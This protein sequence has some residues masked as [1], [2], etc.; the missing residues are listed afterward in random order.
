M[1]FKCGIIGLP[2]VGKTTLFSA[3]TGA[4]AEAVNT[5]KREPNTILVKVPDTRLDRIAELIPPQKVTHAVVEFIDIAGVSQGSS[6]LSTQFL[7][8]MREMDALIHVIR[9]FEDPNVFHI[10]NTLDAVRDAEHLNMELALNDLELCTKRLSTLEKTIRTGKKEGEALKVILEKCITALE[11]GKNLRSLGLTKDETFLLRDLRLLTLK[12]VLYVAN[13]SEADLNQSNPMVQKLEA[14]TKAEN[15]VLIPIC[16][17]IE[18]DLAQ[19]AESER[20]EFMKELHLE[21]SSL[22][23]L[24]RAGYQLL[25]LRT[26]FTAGRK[27]VRAWTFPT[28]ALAPRAAG[29]IHSDLEKNFIRAAVYHCEDLFEWKTEKAIK[30]AGKMRMEGKDYEVQD[31]DVILFH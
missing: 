27:E 1:G 8:L 24:I 10:H 12:K 19:M 2:S 16:A 7:N 22:A 28:G 4:K 26:Y 13:I 14:F 11:E 29:V 31:G 9:C 30:E 25:G 15:S 6:G 5:G 23:K 18:A 20:Q 21:E 17:S 3:L